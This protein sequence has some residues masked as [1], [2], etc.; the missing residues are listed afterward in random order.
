MEPFEDI[1]LAKDIIQALLKAKKTIR[2][3]PENNPVYR[4]TIDDTFARFA[5]LFNSQDELTLKLKQ[6]EIFFNAEQIYYNPDK[7]DNLALFFFKDG[8]RELT[9][10]KSLTPFELED[11][12]KIIALDFDRE[13]VDDDIVT[14]MWEKDFQNIRYVADEA[15][16]MEDDDYESQAVSEI[17]HK[18]P[19]TDEVLKAYASAFEAED[20][21][22]IAIINLTDKDLQLLVKEMEK[23]LLDKSGKIYEILFEMLYQAESAAE[24]EDVHRLLR[25][26]FIYCLKRK[27]LRIVVDIMKKTRDL[28]ESPSTPENIRKQM[29]ILLSSVNSEESVKSVGEIFDSDADIDESL[30]NEYIGFL[31]RNAIIPLMT[32]LGEL[33]SIHGRKVV[34]NI[35]ILLGKKDIQTIAKGLRDP[36]WYVVRNIIYILRHI[37]DKKAVEYLLNTAKHDDER[38]RKEAIKALGELRSPL[39]LQTLRE[40]LNDIEL[41]IRKSAARALGSIGSETAKRVILERISTKDFRDRDFDE[42]K[43]FYEVLTHWNDPEVAEFMT[44]ILKKKS[45]F[46]RAKLDEEKACAAYGLGLMGNKDSLSALYKLKDAKNRLLREHVSVAIKK[47]EYGR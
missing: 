7:E 19:E 12:L 28:A 8:L 46:G 27:D 32:I 2:M 33:E 25:E 1:R 16:L 45:L 20:V 13:A 42:K 15:F 5:E 21:R 31:D 47:V 30:L 14:L 43:D 37:G 41:S 6:N 4:K 40:C 36:R 23:D 44:K 17:K 35:L 26:V 38:V 10:K 22:D 11:F 39:A 34:I 24:Y 18:A 29:N 9:F 3:Y